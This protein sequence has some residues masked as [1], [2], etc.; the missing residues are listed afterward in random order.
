M[1]PVISDNKDSNSFSSL[2]VFHPN[3]SPDKSNLAVAA[4]LSGFQ[5]PNCVF[6]SSVSLFW[7]SLTPPYHN[8]CAEPLDSVAHMVSTTSPLVPFFPPPPL[9]LLLLPIHCHLTQPIQIHRSIHALITAALFGNSKLFFLATLH[10]ENTL[11]K[12]TFSPTSNGCGHND[13]ISAIRCPGQ[14]VIIS[15]P[16]STY[17]TK[18]VCQCTGHQIWHSSH[19]P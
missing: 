15:P 1:T 7:P 18:N 11:M 4:L 14:K 19:S 9:L 10:K 8:A 2:I 6:H 17:T 13:H 5:C 16:G 3:G 12:L